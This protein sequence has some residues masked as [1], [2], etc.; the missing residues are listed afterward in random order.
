MTCEVDARLELKLRSGGDLVWNSIRNLV[1]VC[2]AVPS[3]IDLLNPFRDISASV[4]EHY[5]WMLVVAEL[6]SNVLRGWSC[7]WV[8]R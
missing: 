4:V 1:A 6:L 3:V 5:L 2:G 8:S 7:Y